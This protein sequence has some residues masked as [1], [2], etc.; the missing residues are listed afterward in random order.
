MISVREGTFETNSS[1]CHAMTL[2]VDKDKLERFNKGELFYC[3]MPEIRREDFFTAEEICGALLIL[4]TTT[5]CKFGDYCCGDFIEGDIGDIWNDNF[6]G[7]SQDKKNYLKWFFANLCPSMITWAFS[8]DPSPKYFSK[9]I[10]K[11]TIQALVEE[12]F[13]SPIVTVRDLFNVGDKRWGIEGI[14]PTDNSDVYMDRSTE[15]LLSYRDRDQY[16]V[17]LEFRN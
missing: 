5:E 9:K 4:G 6:E 1:S 13:D 16:R 17:E 11:M 3:Y 15:Q 2:T 8:D 10:I 7:E 12:N 14:S